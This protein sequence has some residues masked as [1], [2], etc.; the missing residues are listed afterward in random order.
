MVVLDV[1]IRKAILGRDEPPIAGI[2]YCGGWRDFENM[3]IACVC[4]YDTAT[5]LT[6]VFLASNLEEL[7]K[8][9]DAE[10]ATGG[11]NTFGFDLKLLA[12]HGIKVDHA[13]HYDALAEIWKKCGLDPGR[14]EPR[15]HG[16]WSLDAIMQG[17]FG[18]AKSGHGAMAPIW[19]QQGKRGRVVDYCA[20]DVW[21]E[22]KLISHMLAGGTIRAPGKPAL[23]GFGDRQAA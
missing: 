17:T 8:Y 13:Q 18:L 16:G 23:S 10:V 19:W 1:E 2:D 11:F 4:T 20:R 12:H 3:G 9:L 14:F 22:A 15:T 7:Q 21:L 6:R 5:H